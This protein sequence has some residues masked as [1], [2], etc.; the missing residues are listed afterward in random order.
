MQEYSEEK[1]VFNGLAHR[2]G[3]GDSKLVL[4]PAPRTAGTAVVKHYAFAPL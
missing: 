2:A 3:C 1:A 4:D